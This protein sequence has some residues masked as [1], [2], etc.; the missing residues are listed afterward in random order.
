MYL[1]EYCFYIMPQEKEKGLKYMSIF[2]DF[3]SLTAEQKRLLSYYEKE[4]TEYRNGRSNAERSVRHVVRTYVWSNTKFLMNEGCSKPKNC[5]PLFGQSHERP[6]LTKTVEDIGYPS[7][8]LTY[9]GIGEDGDSSS[10]ERRAAYWKQW[11]SVVRHEIQV[12]RA[13]V[14]KKVKDTMTESKYDELYRQS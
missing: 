12:K 4:L 10:L 14:M 6:D 3:E 11:E 9:A 13:N 2:D 1:I 8:V 7:V 5:T